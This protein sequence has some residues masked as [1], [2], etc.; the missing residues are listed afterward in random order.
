MPSVTQHY[1]RAAETGKRLVLPDGDRTMEWV[2]ERMVRVRVD[3]QNG[4]LPWPQS[5]FWL[6]R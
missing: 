6:V 5:D 2:D 3:V 4:C 1:I